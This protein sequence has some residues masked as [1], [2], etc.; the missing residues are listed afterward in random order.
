MVLGFS[1]ESGCLLGTQVIIGE[2]SGQ[3]KTPIHGSRHGYMGVCP[4]L[5]AFSFRIDLCIFLYVCF[6]LR[7]GL[8]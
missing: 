8:Y 4:L 2:S 1:I 5:N 6:I 3:W 7:K